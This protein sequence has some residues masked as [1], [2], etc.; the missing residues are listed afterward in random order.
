MSARIIHLFSRLP[1]AVRAD[2]AAPLEPSGP[3]ANVVRLPIGAE[4]LPGTGRNPAFPPVFLIEALSEPRRNALHELLQGNFD[5]CFE[6]SD[7]SVQTR[8]LGSLH[9]TVWLV[10]CPTASILTLLDPVN[11]TELHARLHGG[12]FPDLESLLRYLGKLA[13][14]AIQDRS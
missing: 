1:R 11:G 8:S 9:L 2:C 10:E 13:P 7:Y 5:Q 3:S 6:R 12:D 4:S 14:A